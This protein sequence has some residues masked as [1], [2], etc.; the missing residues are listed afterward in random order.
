MKHKLYL[1]SVAS[2]S[3]GCAPGSLTCTGYGGT[4]DG[5]DLAS[6]T[7]YQQTAG[8]YTELRLCGSMNANW[9]STLDYPF[10]CPFGFGIGVSLPIGP[11]TT[12]SVEIGYAIGG[13]RCMP[14]YDEHG[15]EALITA[16][17]LDDYSFFLESQIEYFPT[18]EIPPLDYEGDAWRSDWVALEGD[19]FPIDL[20]GM[21]RGDSH[22]FGT[23]NV[24][25]HP[26]ISLIGV[27]ESPE[28]KVPVSLSSLPDNCLL[29][30]GCGLVCF[31][32]ATGNRVSLHIR[33]RRSVGSNGIYE[34]GTATLGF[35]NNRDKPSQGFVPL[36]DADTQ[37]SKYVVYPE[38]FE[39]DD[40]INEFEYVS[41]RTPG[42]P[43]DW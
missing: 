7:E 42:Y 2:L 23:V 43:T 24:K 34:G 41:S 17:N 33:Y 16:D 19:L 30:I 32:K 21:F 3:F 18:G 26:D 27:F 31:E 37:S 14:I 11:Q 13:Y 20:A 8:Y 28:F 4:I 22:R 29:S 5:S 1:L 6:R 38:F 15:N 39:S 12:G 40:F 25:N 35:F 9:Q 10:P 36:P